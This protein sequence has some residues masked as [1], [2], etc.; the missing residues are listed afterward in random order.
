MT[1]SDSDVKKEFAKF[2]N[3]SIVVPC[4]QSSSDSCEPDA[5]EE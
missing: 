4:H 1:D 3:P 5:I 2:A